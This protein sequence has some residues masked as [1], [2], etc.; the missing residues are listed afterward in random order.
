VKRLSVLLLKIKKSKKEDQ[1]ISACLK[2]DLQAQKALYERF[3]STMLFVCLRY[4][5]NR[6]EAEDLMI[7]G[8]T[9]VFKKLA[10]FKSDGSFQAWV[11]RI[12]VNEC[13]E[14]LRSNK[15]M[16]LEI[17]LE[18]ADMKAGY[19][20]LPQNLEVEDLMKMIEQLPTGYR[21]VFNLF[22]LEGYSHNEIAQILQISVNTSKSQLSRG[23]KLLQ[24]YLLQSERKLH[25]QYEYNRPIF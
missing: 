13:L 22:A 15:S 3:A 1:L 23:R 14:Y 5:Q 24:Q 17:D 11:R 8:F 12:M 7:K 2:Q 25:N 21:T 4:V 20:L 6:Q 9:K 16:Y 19:A 10:Q 18:K